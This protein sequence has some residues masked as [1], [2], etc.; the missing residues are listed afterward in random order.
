MAERRM[1]TQKI[2]DSDAFTEM[3]LSAQCLYFHLNMHADDDGFLNNANKIRKSINASEDDLKLLILKRFILPFENG[4]VVIKHWRMHNL[5][6]K[7]RYN[8]TQYQDE[9]A[10]L[11]LKS[12]NSYTEKD[13]LT[14]TW[15][16]NDNHLATQ[17]SIGKDS[18]DKSNKD[19]LS[20]NVSNIL[21]ISQGE[22]NDKIPFAD[23]V[24]LIFNVWNNA[25]ITRH[26]T[27]TEEIE[28]AINKAL[29]LY[30]V[31]KICEAIKNY[32]IIYYDKNYFF[33]YKWK[34]VEFLK[35]A[36]ALPTFF[37]EGDKWINYT[38][39]KDG[40]KAAEKEILNQV[41]LDKGWFGDWQ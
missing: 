39:S 22:M 34:L 40:K 14:T 35:Q 13:T 6:R 3:P 9:Y 23:N 27:L 19:I 8:P 18:I 38:N 31:D 28:K 1:F 21:S 15:Q 4:V 36:N 2:T 33:N 11:I 25:D 20:T 10:K 29:S 37:N 24:I 30:G 5:L 26:R 41:P 7:D 16:P 12:D 17:V 32:T